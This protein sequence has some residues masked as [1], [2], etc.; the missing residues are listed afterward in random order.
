MTAIHE[1][2]Q[3]QADRRY[4]TPCGHGYGE[5][6]EKR[7]RFIGQIWNVDSE[8]QAVS[9]INRVK[10]THREA[11]HNV[12]A[13]LCREGNATGYSDDGEPKGTGGMPIL[14]LLRGM[15]LC[16]VCCVVTRYFGG[17]L[18]GT[19]GLARAYT[20]AARLAAEDAGACFV[21]QFSLFKLRFG[22]D[23]FDGL[24]KIADSL[25]GQLGEIIYGSDIYAEIFIPSQKARLFCSQV[26]AFSAGEIIPEVFMTVMKKGARII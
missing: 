14:M 12:Y 15:E 9:C 2:G 22:Y 1:S 17:I 4:K 25:N 21:D 7:S 24:K 3:A 10:E 23:R 16:D 13:Y 26:T 5:Y 11:K 8:Q 6:N 18:L 19:G 20:E